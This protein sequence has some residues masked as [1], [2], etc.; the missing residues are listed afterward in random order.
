MGFNY[1]WIYN[2]LS[3]NG[4]G[5]I[6]YLVIFG[7]YA[8]HDLLKISIYNNQKSSLNSSL[9]IIRDLSDYELGPGPTKHRYGKLNHQTRVIPSHLL[10]NYINHNFGDN[11]LEKIQTETEIVR[12]RIKLLHIIETEM[13]D[14]KS[15]EQI[16]EGWLPN[17]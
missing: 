9:D 5:F 16:E 8:I 1:Y 17:R 10:F 2:I 4:D 14:S 6:T 13:S 11:E 15:L 7:I 12:Y 3:R